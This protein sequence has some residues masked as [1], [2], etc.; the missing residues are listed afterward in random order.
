MTRETLA[1]LASALLPLAL[2][3]IAALAARLTALG[4]QH[5]R[6][7]RLAAA[8]QLAAYGAAGVVADLAQHVVDALKDPTKPG[9]WDQVAANAARGA[10]IGRVKQLYPG[11]VA[12][13]TDALKDPGRVEELLGTLVER[14]VVDL[15]GRTP[16]VAVGELLAIDPPAQSKVP[17]PVLREG[18]RG[19]VR[20]SVMMGICLA[21]IAACGVGAVLSGCPRVIREPSLPPPPDG[22]DAGATLCHQGAPWRC[23]PDGHWSQ[24]DRRCDRLAGDGGTVPVVCCPTPSVLRPSAL[25]HACVPPTVCAPE[26]SR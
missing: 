4:A 21:V 24:A 3:A 13:I 19:V 14:A 20:V 22:C 10:A 17:A 11:A 23:G 16:K 15:K 12:V 1:S 2:L 18:E 26:V 25:V 9:T 6:D 5:I 8:V 7:K